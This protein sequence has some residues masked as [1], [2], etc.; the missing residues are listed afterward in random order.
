LSVDKAL[1]H[2]LDLAGIDVR[3]RHRHRDR[4]IDYHFLFGSRLPYLDDLVAYVSCK[5]HLGACKRLG[6]IFKYKLALGLCGILVEK[7]CSV[8]RD[9]YYLLF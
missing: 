9:L 1:A 3:M 5:F 4:Q 2:I 8:A 6:R 7:L